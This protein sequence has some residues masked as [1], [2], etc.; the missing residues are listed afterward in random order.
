MTKTK[1]KVPSNISESDFANLVNLMSIYSAASHELAE[2]ETEI[3]KDILEK[4]D[5]KKQR[6]AELQEAFSKAEEALELVALA[7]PEWFA[8][9]QS[10]NTPYGSVKFHRST[11][12]EASNE[13]ASI[14][15]I[16]QEIEHLAEQLLDPKLSNE[17]R[18]L[19]E[20]RYAGIK[21][22]IRLREEL[23]LEVLAKLN[24]TELNRFRIVRNSQNNFSA[25]PLKLDM[26]KA[27]KAAIETAKQKAAA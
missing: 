10:L 7:H 9:K 16:K 5:E 17:K 21:N 12:L 13:E 2:L 8:V 15:L 25:K 3:N 4:V 20:E 11:S 23:D 22:A 26:G 27:V 1:L 19:L 14:L 18:A 6:Y 24:D